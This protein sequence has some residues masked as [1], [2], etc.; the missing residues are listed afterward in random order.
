M[1]Q[2]L[3]EVTGG[4]DFRRGTDQWK[5]ISNS[6]VGRL[7]VEKLRIGGHAAHA[8]LDRPP[9]CASEGPLRQYHQAPGIISAPSAAKTKED[10]VRMGISPPLHRWREDI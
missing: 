7:V 3:G 9:S 10:S 2:R 1:S 4:R 8:V 5:N 6:G